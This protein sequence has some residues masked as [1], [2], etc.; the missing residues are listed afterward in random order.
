VKL[1]DGDVVRIFSVDYLPEN[2]IAIGGPVYKP[3]RYALTPGMR[4]ADLIR[5]ADSLQRSTFAER[6]TIERLL[7]NLRRE[8]LSFNIRKAL[9]GDEG[10]NL[11][12]Q[13]ED[14]VAV[15]PEA[16]FFPRRSVTI[17]GAVRYPGAY[18]RNDSMSV[19]DLIITAGGLTDRARLDGIEI[20]RMD[21]TQL[22]VFS[23]VHRVNLPE[24]YWRDDLTDFELRDL[25]VVTIPE[26]P[27]YVPPK[28]VSITGYVMSPGT[29][30]I[31]SSEER[32]A[33]LFKRA[34]G[35]KV[36]AYIDGAR[37]FRKFNNAGMVPLDFRQALDDVSSRDNVVLYDGDS[38]H[39]PL[40]EDVVYVSGEVFVPSPVL[41]KKGAGLS[42]YL[43][44]AGGTKDEADDGR[45]VVMLPGGKKWSGGG[46]FGGD[47][48]LP[49]STIFVPKKI[50]K[51]DKTLPVLR[52]MATILA[53]IA[54]ITIGII[55]ITK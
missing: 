51:E 29:Y 1:A 19:A 28:L 43:D 52:D 38:V 13:N 30:T 10:E 48:I 36:G 11:L 37:L 55:Q 25:D 41:Y 15:Y 33:E 47:E 45:T 22:G 32:L 5:R 18:A 23:T 42:F 40:T 34:G 39:V 44:Q 6:G 2:R 21:T 17:T 35:L 31:R 46:L 53:S 27:K 16:M 3:G 54:A 4:V 20:G 8:I 14:S 24:D 9:A 12:L 49:G 26:N 7:P 50:E